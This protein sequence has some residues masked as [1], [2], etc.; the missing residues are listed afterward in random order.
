ML[1]DLALLAFTTRSGLQFLFPLAN[2]ST[3]NVQEDGFRIQIDA[4]A[5]DNFI[6]LRLGLLWHT[7]FLL[8][9]DVCVCFI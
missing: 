4:I 9:F 2:V 6:G 3:Q 8:N 1:P 5:F 7:V